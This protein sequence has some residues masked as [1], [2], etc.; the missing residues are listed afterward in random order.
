MTLFINQRLLGAAAFVLMLAYSIA[1]AAAPLDSGLETILSSAPRDSVI[2]VLVAPSRSF[3]L[4]DLENQLR[5]GRATRKERHRRVVQALKLESARSQATLVEFLS[6]E[7]GKGKVKSY[8]AFWIANIV[9]VTTTASR[10][11][12]LAARPDVGRVLENRVIKL[13]G[14]KVKEGGKTATASS[15]ETLLADNGK[16]FNWALEKMNVRPLWARGLTGRGILVGN[17]D[18]GVD[19]NHPALASKW[20][21][22]HGATATESWFDPIS[23]SSFPFDD[24]SG[25]HGTGTMGC[26]LGQ[27]GADTVGVAPDA[28]WIAAKAFEPGMPGDSEK[29]I[30]CLQWMAD[31]DG[32]P[33]T[34]DDVPDILNLSFGDK[35]TTSCVTTF[36]ESLNNLKALGV[37]PIV[38]SGN[39]NDHGTKIAAPG[40]SPDFFAVTAVDSLNQYASHSMP[41]PSF[42][43]PNIIKPDIVAPGHQVRLAKGETQFSAATYHYN[44]GSSFACPLVSGVAALV[45]QA[46]PELTPDEVYEVL[47]GSATDL[48]VAGPD[49]L[50]GYGAINADSAVALAGTP[51][52]P[53]LAITNIELNAGI[54]ELVSPGEDISVAL[55]LVNN[56]ISAGSVTATVTSNSSDVT[57]ALGDLNFGAIMAGGSAN[58]N[59]V[60]FALSFSQGIG[61][62]AIR[63]FNVNITADDK[64]QTLAF[65]VA[66]GGEPPTVVE[67]YATHDINRAGLSITNYGTIGTDGQFGGGFIYPRASALSPEHLFQG[68]L[69]IGNGPATISDASYKDQS[70]AGDT[71]QSFNHDFK[72]VT[73]GNLEISQP[74][75]FADQEI[76]AVFADS[77]AD[78]PLGVTVF[79]RSYG[80]SSSEYDD[81]VIVEYRITG[82]A[83]STLKGLQV[84]QHIDWDVNDS[85][86]EDL[87]AFE[88]QNGLVYSF[89]SA[90][91]N[92][93][94]NILLTQDISGFGIMSYSRDIDDGFKEQEKWAAMTNL[95]SA[96]TVTAT[97]DD[98]NY[99]LSSGPLFIK[100]GAE[101][102]VAFAVVGG[103]G[104]DDLRANAAAARTK[105]AEVAA[106]RSI[107]MVDPLVTVQPMRNQ[108]PQMQNYRLDLTAE[109]SAST[110]EQV[111]V[112]WRD[113]GEQ[114]SA[115]AY[116]DAGPLSLNPNG[117]YAAIL[118]GRTEG[119]WVEYYIRAI[120]SQGNQGFQ[121]ANA[122]DQLYNFYVGDTTRPVI[123]S[124]GSSASP[125]GEGM[126]ITA[127]VTDSDLGIVTA[128]LLPEGQSPDTLAMSTVETENTFS[129]L[130]T[131]LEPGV[132][133]SYYVEATDTLGNVARYPASAPAE[134]LQLVF[135][136]VLAGDGDLNGRV[137]IFDVLAV[138][139]VISGREEPSA[140]EFAAMDLDFDGRISIFDLLEVLKLLRK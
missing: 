77:N 70:V 131:G 99:I 40:N 56:G 140:S 68:G 62:Q 94:G 50:F 63:T 111:R 119:T 127:T 91:D 35:S 69:M 13:S 72:A 38:A 121:P 126:L 16:I 124:V 110:V 135:N 117:G 24:D 137:D 108:A 53:W 138:L 134:L 15:G 86:D 128:I 132:Q 95:P 98:Y 39:L 8:R 66:V 75:Q 28:Q 87:V 58:N 136:P 49:T 4:I 129:A 26:M 96:D 88:Y 80:W 41:G 52:R 79:Q 42:C 20:R 133:V 59:S 18:S 57:V 45:R 5:R 122:P 112:F 130:V 30:L 90:G 113:S 123:S 14:G 76:T 37:T 109:D 9:A 44:N 6:A 51:S 74:G 102:T 101:V 92:Y 93:I 81:F 47:R 2:T 89:D 27:S 65:A 114:P 120:D 7:R 139:K 82:P 105:W 83:D 116:V 67:T 55:T 106:A 84:A 118:P 17:I 3:D 22:A 29:I 32:D 73:G 34:V 19:G 31:P 103:E 85:N 64:T 21:G 46:N 125:G 104:L 48:G 60:P 43:A 36:W 23:G 97:A 25:T 61:Q 1:G 11:A 10:V 107:D 12:E 78:L 71:E 115:W 100:P 33:A 54:D